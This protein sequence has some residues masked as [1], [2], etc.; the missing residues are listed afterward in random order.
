MSSPNSR[1]SPSIR[2]SGFSSCIRLMARRK[3]DLPQPL[4]P[5]MAV[6]ARAAISIVILLSTALSL[7]KI[8]SPRTVNAVSDADFCSAP[9][10][11]VGCE[12]AAMRFN[13][14]GAVPAEPVAGQHADA[15]VDGGNEQ[16]QDQRARPRLP[17]PVVVG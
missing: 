3:V 9:T 11:G 2:A 10:P 1:I 5:M 8:E 17:V 16:N 12:M 7:K 14:S 15:D 13:F 4:G 6:A